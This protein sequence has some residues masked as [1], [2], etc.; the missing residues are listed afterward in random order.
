[1]IITLQCCACKYCTTTILVLVV[2]GVASRVVYE[3]I[4][5]W[6]TELVVDG[7]RVLLNDVCTGH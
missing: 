4:R 7:V 5:L 2:A 6:T 3:H 1:M